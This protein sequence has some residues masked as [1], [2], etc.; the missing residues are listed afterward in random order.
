[1]DRRAGLRDKSAITHLSNLVRAVV[2]AKNALTAQTNRSAQGSM[3][4]AD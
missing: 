1:M 2:D 3:S 4:Q